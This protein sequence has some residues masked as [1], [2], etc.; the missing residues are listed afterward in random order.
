MA[1]VDDIML[2]IM[3]NKDSS[4]L[5]LNFVTQLKMK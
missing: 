4:H 5:H 3:K 2:E 1:K